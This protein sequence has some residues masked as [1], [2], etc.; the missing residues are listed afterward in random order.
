[1]KNQVRVEMYAYGGMDIENCYYSMFTLKNN[2]EVVMGGPTMTLNEVIV[3]VNF[4]GDVIDTSMTLDECY[5]TIAGCTQNEFIEK[6]KKEAEKYAEEKKKIEDNFEQLVDSYK[7]RSK[8]IIKQEDWESFCTIVRKCID[9]MYN[10]LELDCF[11]DIVNLY[12]ES[13]NMESCAKLFYKQGHSGNSAGVVSY[14][15]KRFYSE[16]LGD[17]VYNNNLKYGNDE[18]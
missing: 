3:F 16:E 12:K 18:N 14:L 15:I 2:L 5:I 10:G 8:S 4:N 9:G 1:M 13:E 11:I 17:Y 6:L 7:E